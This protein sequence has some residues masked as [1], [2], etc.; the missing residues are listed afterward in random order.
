MGGLTHVRLNQANEWIARRIVLR[1]GFRVLGYVIFRIL[2]LVDNLLAVI[3]KHVGVDGAR[4][5]GELLHRFR[6]FVLQLIE[7]AVKDV[8]DVL[9]LATEEMKQGKVLKWG[10][11]SLTRITSKG[12]GLGQ[13]VVLKL[14]DRAT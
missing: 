3:F 14:T 6:I 4:L 7:G 8:G 5:I 1:G 2:Y 11:T 10:A 12:E 13:R 9:V